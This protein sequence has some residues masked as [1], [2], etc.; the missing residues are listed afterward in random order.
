[1]T[2]FAIYSV[3]HDTESKKFKTQQMNNKITLPKDLSYEMSPSNTLLLESSGKGNNDKIH[4]SQNMPLLLK[5]SEQEVSIQQGKK[6][7]ISYDSA[8]LPE[9]TKEEEFITQQPAIDTML[10][11]KNVKNV[12]AIFKEIEQC[13]KDLKNLSTHVQMITNAKAFDRMIHTPSIYYM[14]PQ[15]ITQQ[16]TTDSTL[17]TKS[18]KVI[19]SVREQLDQFKEEIKNIESMHQQIITNVKAASVEM[20]NKWNNINDKENKLRGQNT[21]CQLVAKKYQDEINK[22]E[23]EMRRYNMPDEKLKR[24]TDSVIQ[25]TDMMNKISELTDEVK[26]LKLENQQCLELIKE[27]SCNK[28]NIRFKRREYEVENNKNQ[29]IKHEEC[30][31]DIYIIN[32][33]ATSYTEN[34]LERRL[35]KNHISLITTMAEKIKVNIEQLKFTTKVVELDNM[36]NILKKEKLSLLSLKNKHNKMF[37][38]EFNTPILQKTFLPEES[39]QKLSEANSVSS[40]LQTL[41]QQVA[42]VI[43]DI[44]QN[45]I[46]LPS[47]NQYQINLEEEDYNRITLPTTDIADMKMDKTT[48]SPKPEDIALN[49]LLELVMTGVEN[50]IRTIF[51]ENLNKVMK[52]LKNSKRN[53]NSTVVEEQVPNF[54]KDLNKNCITPVIS[55]IE[56]QKNQNVYELLPPTNYVVNKSDKAEESPKQIDASLVKSLT[57]YEEKVNE[58]QNEYVIEMLEILKDLKGN[59]LDKSTVVEQVSNQDKVAN[60]KTETKKDDIIFRNEILRQVLIQE[61]INEVQN[62]DYIKIKELLENMEKIHKSTSVE[63][64]AAD[65]KTETK[66]DDSV[67]KEESTFSIPL[68]SPIKDQDIE[69][70]IMHKSYQSPSSAQSDDYQSFKNLNLYQKLTNDTYISQHDEKVSPNKVDANVSNNDMHC[71]FCDVARKILI[72]CYPEYDI[73]ENMYYIKYQPIENNKNKDHESM[74]NVAIEEDQ[75]TEDIKES[76]IEVKSID[77]DT[78]SYKTLLHYTEDVDVIL[79]KNVKAAKD[80]TLIAEDTSNVAHKTNYKLNGKFIDQKYL[81]KYCPDKMFL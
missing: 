44:D 71:D 79:E 35:E 47:V 69:T 16:S 46:T 68:F 6:F 20:T 14:S 31:S 3:I 29:E 52:V 60:D 32:E 74:L 39:H 61:E 9:V 4:E 56:E 42:E 64:Q 23:F 1:M 62:E 19:K 66:K 21:Y 78:T 73:S 7:D 36:Y 63:E 13:E 43:T 59:K 2:K 45:N 75:T 15:I 27:S 57:D 10:S 37:R 26:K 55:Q 25:N 49:S 41:K 17:S 54:S 11:K 5:P 48:E 40:N 77:S 30:E 58:I 76:E 72:T 12:Q 50:K 34:E 22:H 28:E 51:S 81:S 67:Y 33:T 18:T 65:D 53:D 70:N 8:N 80:G 38:T 24:C